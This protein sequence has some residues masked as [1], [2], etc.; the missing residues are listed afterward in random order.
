MNADLDE[1]FDGRAI[2]ISLLANRRLNFCFRHPSSSLFH[3][4]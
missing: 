1:Q 4:L 2:E 3:Y